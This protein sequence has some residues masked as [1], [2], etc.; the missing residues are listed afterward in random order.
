MGIFRVLKQNLIRK[1]ICKCNV[2]LIITAEVKFLL[3]LYILFVMRF[4][5]HGMNTERAWYKYHCLIISMF[6]DF[7]FS[8]L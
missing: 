6:K 7:S 5:E 2:F 3:H 1:D 8:L 4:C